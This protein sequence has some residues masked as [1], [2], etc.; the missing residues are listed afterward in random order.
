MKR[1]SNLILL[2]IPTNSPFTLSSAKNPLR[3]ACWLSVW[4]LL[5]SLAGST[6][7]QFELPTAPA[8]QARAWKSAQLDSIDS[9]L[10]SLKSSP[11]E[12]ELRSQRRWLAAWQP[13]AM[14]EEPLWKPPKTLAQQKTWNEPLLD[15]SGKA[16]ELR[17]RLL[18]K[19]AKPTRA[20]TD[21]LEKAINA[22]PEDLGL[23]QL[24][25]HWIDQYEFRKI[26]QDDIR[27]AAQ[28]VTDLIAKQGVPQDDEEAAKLIMARRFALYRKVRAIAYRDLPEVTEKRPIKSPKEFDALLRGAYADLMSD[29]GAG[30]QEFILIEIR[31]LRRD[32]LL[33]S[34]LE[35]LEDYGSVIEPKWL[36]KKRRDILK[37]LGWALPSDEAAELYAPFEARQ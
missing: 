35:R 5:W 8:S 22:A 3:P 27:R 34:A 17:K 21:A 28:A 6:S 16:S 13:G 37:E 10:K 7:A 4:G 9:Q 11:L 25:L 31:M 26:H 2:M 20:D 12:S 1:H 23:R 30:R 24:Y 36:L 18:G 15:P 33:G 14:S 19:G 29:A 32:A